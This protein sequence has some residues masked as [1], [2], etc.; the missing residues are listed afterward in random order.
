M[1]LGMLR[2]PA[3]CAMYVLLA[4]ADCER[5]VNEP[6]R[7]C[8]PLGQS[9]GLKCG[10]G[11]LCGN[12]VLTSG[13]GTREYGG[14]TPRAHGLWPSTTNHSGDAPCVGP[15][16]S[17]KGPD[18]TMHDCFRGATN[19][20]RLQVHEW[21]AH[22]VCA[23]VLDAKDY[24]TQTCVLAS[25]PLSIMN[26]SKASSLSDIAQD[27]QSHGICVWKL[28][29]DRYMEIYLSACV[30]KDGQWKLADARNFSKECAKKY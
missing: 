11:V 20:T 29:E 26:K 1:A 14:G 9:P 18:N 21:K 15:T 10:K 6:G 23:G 12:L 13:L 27:L 28:K 16:Q 4:L 30:G 8:S 2:V 7:T 19:A 24:L 5:L 25:E 22:G 17:S 3:A